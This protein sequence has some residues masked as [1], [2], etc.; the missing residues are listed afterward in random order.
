MTSPELHRQQNRADGWLGLEMSS[1]LCVGVVVFVIIVTALVR[2]FRLE[3]HARHRTCRDS[4]L[5][6]VNLLDMYVLK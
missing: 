1:R 6:L 4:G 5:A 3:T 2:K